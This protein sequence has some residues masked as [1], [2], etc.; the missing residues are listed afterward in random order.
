ML[1]NDMKKGTTGILKNNW[2]FRIEDNKSGNTRLATV[3]GYET[4]TGSIYI[5]DIVNVDLPD[6]TAEAIEL[7]KSQQKRAD[8]ISNF[9]G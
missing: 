5:H 7:S 1:A 3:Y 8:L 9:W 6:G 2:K 4:E